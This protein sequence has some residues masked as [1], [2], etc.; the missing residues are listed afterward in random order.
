MC[1]V[2]VLERCEASLHDAYLPDSDEQ[3]YNEPMPSD[4]DALLQ[5]AQTMQYLHRRK[6]RIHFNPYNILFCNQQGKVCLKLAHSEYLVKSDTGVIFNP[7]DSY[8][9]LGDWAVPEYYRV[10]E[11]K[12][13]YGT[14]STSGNWGACFS[15]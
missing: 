5:M 6:I 2:T 14:N 15:T 11:T 4:C 1:R 9:Y 12:L 13:T 7:Y 10:R 3:K 8:V